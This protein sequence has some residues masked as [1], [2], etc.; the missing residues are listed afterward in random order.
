MQPV[1][2]AETRITRIF[3]LGDWIVLRDAVV[4]VISLVG[5]K[6]E[7]GLA[8]INRYVHE[9]LLDLAL[10]APETLTLFGKADCER[11]TVHA[12]FR[13]AEAVWVE[14][15]EDGQHFVRHSQFARLTS[16]T[17]RQRH[18]EGGAEP[19]ARAEPLHIELVPPP[20]PALTTDVGDQAGIVTTAIK[21]AATKEED[22]LPASEVARPKRGRPTKV[23][24]DVEQ[25]IFRLLD[26]HG[27][28][29]P[30]DPDWSS[31]A[32]IE[33]ILQERAGLEKT[34]AREH[35]RRLID[36]WRAGKA[37]N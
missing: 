31:Q 1:P 30:N 2:E 35:A 24:P 14:P 8:L 10:L 32:N 33:E 22:V 23:T 16:P 29:D 4:Q 20:E 28:P 11:R 15:R 21:A 5:E 25:H 17:D 36:A 7:L 37:G 9:G 6:R 3:S 12:A 27:L 18:A 34:Q 19:M 26:H 13:P